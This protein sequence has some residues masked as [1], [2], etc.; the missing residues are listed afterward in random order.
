MASK[1]TNAPDPVSG[2][3]KA[4]GGRGAGYRKGDARREEILRGVTALFVAEGYRRQSLRDIGAA[5]AIEPAHILY[6]FSNREELLQNVIELWDSDA[7]R[8]QDEDGAGPNL[9]GFVAAV[10]RNCSAAGMGHLFLAMA[11]D[12]VDPAHVSHAF[13]CQR[14]TRVRTSL[15]LAVRAEQVSGRIVA[16]VDPDLSARNLMGLADGLQLQA[17]LQG[18]NNVVEDLEQAI[19]H[20]R[21]ED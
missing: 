7:M 15:A 14:V 5:L 9:E 21:G 11:V 19:R 1:S 17:L 6:Y 13:F 3:R 18:R 8:A 2:L 20:L 16:T 12:A 10:R 4:S